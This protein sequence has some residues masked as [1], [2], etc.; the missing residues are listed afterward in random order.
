MN[1]IQRYVL[2]EILGPTGLGLVVFT[3]VF[4]IGQMFT[5]A[6]YLL[7]SGIPPRLGL[8]LILLI[9][10]GLMSITIPMAVLVGVLMGIGRLAADREILAIKA[11]G[12]SVVRLA[13]PIIAFTVGITS[14]M[15]LANV[16]LVPYLNLKR[17]DLQVQ[18]LFHALSAIPAGVPFKMPSKGRAD[19]SSIFISSKDPETGTMQGVAILAQMESSGAN[20]SFQT[21]ISDLV[22]TDIEEVLR[23]T[24]SG[25]VADLSDKA[26]EAL[27]KEDRLA[28]RRLK[29]QQEWNEKINKP[30]Q[31]VF[32][33]AEE[34]VFDPQI[35]D[36]AVYV[37]LSNGS[38]HI[39]DPEDKA[40]YDV[41]RFDNMTRGLVPTFDKI[42]KGY[43]EK[44]PAEMSVGELRH[45]ISTRQKGGK[46]A[47]E[48]YQ[49]F[50][51][52]LACIAF[53]LIAF[54]LAVYVRPT[55]KAVAFGLSFLLILIYYGLLQY[56]VAL[57]S[58][59]AI[60]LPNLLIAGVGVFM[61]YRI[62][63]R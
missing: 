16:K 51:V 15:M 14:I 2:R 19:K 4:L 62:T 36:R 1:T 10:P 46:Y 23:S 56:G 31:D 30:V 37:R 28:L 5:L 9:L 11:S 57:G 7:N 25:R 6:D 22:T 53:A 60:F 17:A 39:T 52:P 61:L 38:I 45:Q 48:L 18:I 55:G 26:K 54:P 49:R 12:I 35:A 20:D 63:T 33:T 13:I 42:E 27:S 40:A 8:E 21:S 59:V 47:V 34:G 41:I 24:N 32:I 29:Q 43:F 3:F 50:S 44:A 58:A